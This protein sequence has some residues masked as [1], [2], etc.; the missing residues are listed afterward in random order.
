MSL[1]QSALDFLAGP[2]SLGGAA[3]RDQ[4]DF[5]GQTVEM[6]ELRLRVR[7]V[8]AEGGFAFVYEAQDLGSG[9]EYALKRL[10]S[11][12]EEKNRAII[13]EVCFMKKLSGHPNIVQF[14]SAASIGK[15]ESDTGQA[16]FLLLMELCRGQLVEFLKKVESKGP[17]SCD[18]VL[19]IFYQ[20]CR[21]V[22]HLHRQKPPIIHRDLKVENL[23][24]SN[25]GTIK[26]CDFGSATTI[27]HYPD[28]SWSA[29]RRALVEEE[30]TRN[31]TPMYR[32]PEIVDLYSNFPIGEKQD[33]WALGC[34]LYLLCFGQHPFEDGAKLRI[35]NGKYA[36][37]ADD[38]RYSVFHGLIRATLKVNPEERLSIT[39]LV[40]QLQEIAAARN[41]NP[42]SPITELLEQNGGY[43]HAAPPGSTGSSLVVAECEQPYGGL[44]DILRGGTERLFTNIKGTSS[45]VIQSVANYAKGDLDLSYITSRIAVMSFPAEGV[46]S[47][48]K[49]NIEDV[50]LFLDSKHPGRYAVYNLSPRTY[51]PSK[52]HNR[53]SDCGWAARRAPSLRSLYRLCR[54]MHAW[55]RRDPGNVCVVH[56]MD[57][58]AASAVAVCSFLC[59]CRLFSTAE[60]AVYMFSMKR[61]PPGIWP[62]HKRYIEYMCDMVAEEPVTP[63]SKPLLVKAVVMTPVPLFSKQRSGC[64]PFCE[65]YV[66]DE[67]VTTTSQEYDRMRDFKIE[68]GKA[69]IPLGI[70]VQGDVLIVIYHARST[71]GGRLQAKMASMKMF[72]IQFHTGFVPRNAATVKFAKYDLDACDIQEKYPDLFQVS[73]EVE[74][75]PRDKPGREAPPWEG[76]GMRGLNPKILFSSREEQQ[77]VLSKFGKPEL[78]RQPGSTAQ[79]DAEARPAD[80]EPESDSPHRSADA[81]HFLHTLDWREDRDSTTGPE[82]HLAEED[83]SVV[84]EDGCGSEPSDEEA[85]T[86]SAES[87]DTADEDAPDPTAPQEDSV[88]LLGLHAEAGPAPTPQAPGGPPSNADLLSCLLG[89]PG[90]TPEGAAGGLLDRDTA[91]LF[92]SPAPASRTQTTA[93]AADPFGP[94]LLPPDTDAAPSSQPDLFGEFLNSAAPATQPT[95]FPSTHSAPP[96]ACSTNFL[97]LGDL[98]AEPSKMTASAS[99]PDLLGAWDAWAEAPAPALAADGPF[100]SPGDQ[101]APSG[102]P[103]SQTKSQSQDPF[104]DIGD[105]SSGLQGSPAAAAPGGFS[106]KAAPPPKASGSWQTSRPPA[107]GTPWPPQAKPPPKASVQPRPNYTSSFSVIGSR[108]ERGVRAPSFGPKPRVSEND[109]EDLLPSQGFSSRADRKGPRTIAEM[110]RQDQ[111][112]DADPLKLKLLEWTEG[113][114]RNIRALLSTLHTALWDGESRW[115][116]VGMADLVTPAQVKKHYRRAVLVVHPDK[117]RGQPYEQYARMIFMELSDAWAEFESQGS[118][119]LF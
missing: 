30:I 26:L 68:D 84:A 72:Q 23:L 103:A 48:I 65:V 111:A 49:N 82:G 118:R 21:A 57:G 1:L 81:D 36:I 41:V 85:P 75:E 9:R 53:V 93:P 105:L 40:N 76:A 14:C 37:P 13:Q 20:T 69:V 71:L 32:T 97:R 55:L 43:G 94:L 4:T 98:P 17:L 107:Q 51:R 25:Q 63:H 95:P 3:A 119:P 70:T 102:L 31:T 8:L 87:G 16:E 18:T 104:A 110:R 56:C 96:P 38:T 91:L 34:I 64:R 73:L 77:D 109:F 10:L 22:Q 15:E 59:F 88:D 58:R 67:R 52:F 78:P 61:C 29:Q 92:S 114:E 99:H 11:N 79:Y 74:V 60:A 27:S 116:P 6:G 90:P 42:K 80:A 2:G 12:E 115:T 28:Y 113:K 86:P 5:V 39:E 83:P 101:P 47:A 19:K 112:R 7:R 44:L 66:G 24:L 33:I 117:A 108:E 100:F 45:K 35:V 106:P 62:S 54:N 89:A 46:E 50:R